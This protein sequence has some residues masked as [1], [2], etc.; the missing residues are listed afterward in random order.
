MAKFRVDC[1]RFLLGIVLTF[2][3]TTQSFKSLHFIAKVSISIHL[4]TDRGYRQREMQF[5]SKGS[6]IWGFNLFKLQERGLSK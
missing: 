3:S 6:K 2:V 4:N 5:N 1:C